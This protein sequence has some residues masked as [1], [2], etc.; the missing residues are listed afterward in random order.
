MAAGSTKTISAN[1]TNP[2]DSAKLHVYYVLMNS[3]V[4][5]SAIYHPCW[6]TSKGTL[7]RIINFKNKYN[8]LLKTPCYLKCEIL[9]GCDNLGVSTVLRIR[10]RG[11]HVATSLPVLQILPALVTI[12]SQLAMHR[13]FE[14]TKRIFP[15]RLEVKFTEKRDILLHLEWFKR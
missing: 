9:M 2:V 3:T 10:N 5:T 6:V 14:F 4:L 1:P 15:Q 8:Y 13:G 11:K 7:C 12:S